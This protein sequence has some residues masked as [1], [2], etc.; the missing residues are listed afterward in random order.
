MQFNVAWNAKSNVRRLC[1]TTILSAA[2]CSGMGTSSFAQDTSGIKP[3]NVM[4]I[5]DASGSMKRSA[6]M[7]PRIDA[8]KRAFSETLMA[9]PNHVRT[10]LVAFGHRR[11]AECRDIEVVSVAGSLPRQDIAARVLNFEAL[12]ETPIGQSLRIAGQAMA[13]LKN[14]N[15]TIVLIT[16]GIEECGGDP[17]FEAAELNRLGMGVKVHVVGFALGAG[18]SNKLRCVVDQTGGTFFEAS[19]VGTLKQTLAQ[20]QKI[21]VT[22]TPP[23]PPPPVAASVAPPP[24]PAPAAKVFFIDEFDGTKLAED[25]EVANPKPANFGV[26]KGKLLA[27]IAGTS[28]F[29]NGTSPNRF[30]LKKELPGGDWDLELDLRPEFT[31]SSD[32]TWLGVYKDDKNFIGAYLWANRGYCSELTVSIIK[33]TDGEESIYNRR[34]AGSTTCG[35]GKADVPAVLKQLTDKGGKLLLSKRGR[36]YTATAVMNPGV[37]DEKAVEVTT[38]ALSVLRLTGDPAFMV[39]QHEAKKGETLISV[40]RFRILEY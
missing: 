15:N 18:D 37:I 5:F 25:W 29:R 21:V 3:T 6:G 36:Q 14:E 39:A 26:E 13:A 27:F 38:D 4:F 28:G 33:R 32:G 35:W 10:G 9:M 12:G 16:D 2:L 1:A 34:I 30:Q 20:V 24:P 31:S 22:E 17:C 7:E 8:A 19:D 40:E 23:P 11:R